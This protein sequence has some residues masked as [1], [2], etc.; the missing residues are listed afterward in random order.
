LLSATLR[1]I[2]AENGAAYLEAADELVPF[3]RHFGF[4]VMQTFD[5]PDGPTV[6]GMWRAARR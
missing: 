3:Y 5:L 1:R 6:N 4:A 2:D